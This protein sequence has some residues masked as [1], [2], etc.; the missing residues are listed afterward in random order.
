L[1]LIPFILILGFYFEFSYEMFGFF[2]SISPLNQWMLFTPFVFCLTFILIL[3]FDYFLFYF[4][5][6]YQIDF[7]FHFHSLTLKYYFSFYVVLVSNLIPFILILDHWFDLFCKM[8]FSFS[9]F[10]L[11]SINVLFTLIFCLTFDPY[12]FT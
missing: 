11:K 12:S 8:Y 10:T 5:T 1:N 6:F 9:N 2:F 3:L 4:R 7:F